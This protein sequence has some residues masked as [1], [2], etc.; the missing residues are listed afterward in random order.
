MTDIDP[1]RLRIRFPADLL[2]AVPYLV[3]FHPADSVVVV[4]IRGEQLALAVRGDLPP[5]PS[6]VAG[7][8]ARQGVDAA[9]IIG[10]GPAQR[11]SPAV[12]QVRDALLGRGIDVYDALR[13]TDGRYWSYV[14]DNPSCCPPEGTPFD[15]V[16]SPV[17]AQ[18]AYCGQ[19]ALPSRA[20]LVA[21]LAPVEGPAR[22][23]MRQ[24]T[25]RAQAR[26]DQLATAEPERAAVDRLQCAAGAE[27][28]TGALAR[29][30]AGDRLTDDE[31]AWLAV[32]LGCVA[33]RDLAWQRID[34]S[35]LHI[36]VWT[37]VVQRAEPHLAAPP[38][39]L[40]AFAAWRLGEGALAVVALERALRA[41][42]GYPLALLLDKV[43]RQGIAPTAV[44]GWPDLN[45]RAGRPRRSRTRRRAG[46]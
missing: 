43:L 15:P 12:L 1:P 4:G 37:D 21:R 34:E 25:A 26:L 30:S 20:A 42:P 9:T 8:V 23:S 7:I 11:V 40:L 28:V 41:D 33:V 36:G 13:V 29:H 22:V 19:E 2:A 5:V 46:R 39:S 17:A 3:G 38:A 32:L 16:S 31:V 27:A 6:H 18:F 14:C 44:A 35:R 10:Y 45:G 24:A